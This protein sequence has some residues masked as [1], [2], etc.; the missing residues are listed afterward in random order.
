VS[1][2]VINTNIDAINAYNNLN[3]TNQAMS[4]AVSELSS[5]LRVQTAA[6]DASGYVISQYLTSESNGLDQAITN[7]QDAVAVLQTASGAMNQITSL[8]QRMNEL[9]TQAANGGATFS[10]A[11]Q[12]DNQE[13]SDLATQITQIAQST[14]FGSTQLLDGTYSNQTFQLGAYNASADQVSVSI[15]ELVAGSL[16]FDGTNVASLSLDSTASA[17]QAMSVVQAAIAYVATVEANIGA[18]QDQIQSLVANMTVGQQNVTAAN[19]QIIDVNMAK[20]MTVY[21]ADQILM[22][23]GTAMLSQAQQNPS[24]VLKLLQ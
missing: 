2:L 12:A 10:T 1:A 7:G 8:L 4:Q 14:Q 16:A 13:F 6:Q 18:L 11:Q 9:A 3:A 23:A 24:L 22:Q 19:S 17:Q 15:P 21:S 20:E 5:G